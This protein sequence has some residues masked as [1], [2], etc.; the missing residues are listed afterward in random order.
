MIRVVVVV[1]VVISICGALDG[2]SADIIG[3]A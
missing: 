2:D 1:I 3:K